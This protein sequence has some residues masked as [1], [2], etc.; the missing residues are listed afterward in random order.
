VGN[1]AVVAVVGSLVVVVVGNLIVVESNLVVVVV[2]F[3]VEGNLVAGVVHRQAAEFGNRSASGKSS[4]VLWVLESRACAPRHPQ[5]A[6]QHS[7][8][9]FSLP[10]HSAENKKKDA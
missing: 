1:L 9:C 5:S 2:V 10:K 3:L 8:K 4:T 7:S 6:G